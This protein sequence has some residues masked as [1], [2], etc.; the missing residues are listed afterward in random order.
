MERY[1]SVNNEG[2]C[3]KDNTLNNVLE[4]DLLISD[5]IYNE[6]LENQSQ[7]KEYKILNENGITFEEIFQEIQPAGL[8][9]LQELESLDKF[10]PRCVEDMITASGIDITTLPQI[11]QDRLA[12]KQELRTQL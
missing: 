2:F 7:G 3:F 9:P 10:L 11:M 1:L 8:T 4:T 12:R 6:F 5:E